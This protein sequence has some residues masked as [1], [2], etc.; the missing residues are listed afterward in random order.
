M[1]R[2]KEVKETIVEIEENGKNMKDDTKTKEDEDESFSNSFDSL[3]EKEE[4]P[5]NV[6]KRTIA[7]DMKRMARNEGPSMELKASVPVG[8]SV[9][10]NVMELK[11]QIIGNI[12]ITKSRVGGVE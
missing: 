7:K 11:V 2:E 5:Q 9:C 10:E 3:E 8:A 1:E 12:P 4:A 6:Q